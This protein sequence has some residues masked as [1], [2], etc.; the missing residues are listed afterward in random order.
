METAQRT[1]TYTIT[2]DDEAY[3]LEL[4]L[5]AFKHC[6]NVM[7]MINVAP[8][9]DGHLPLPHMKTLEHLKFIS[10]FLHAHRDDEEPVEEKEPV[11]EQPADG[12]SPDENAP[13]TMWKNLKETKYSEWDEVNVTKIERLDIPDFLKVGLFL[14][15]QIM[16]NAF[17]KRLA[18]V[19]MQ[20]DDKGIQDYFGI[21][22]EFTQAEHDAVREK[23]PL[24]FS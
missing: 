15:N 6:K 18:T 3:C 13:D 14:G 2:T 11:A 21:H 20:Y 8:D 24:P 19:I 16:M 9:S 17:G 23:Y 1:P 22:R 10:A 7:A 5:E 4:P 12:K